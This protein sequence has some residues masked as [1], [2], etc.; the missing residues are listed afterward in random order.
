M[1]T[2]RK[3]PCHIALLVLVLILVVVLVLVVLL[4]VLV[5]LVAFTDGCE[6]RPSR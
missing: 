2:F 6:W 4:V 5:V 1:H 3:A